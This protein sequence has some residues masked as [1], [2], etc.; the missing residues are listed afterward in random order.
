VNLTEGDGGFVVLPPS[1]HEFRFSTANVAGDVNGDSLDDF[2]I[3]IK[4]SESDEPEYM[5]VVFGKTDTTSILLADVANGLGGFAIEI[6]QELSFPNPVKVG[7]LNGDGLADIAVN[8][9]LDECYVVFGKSSTAAVNPLDLAAGNGGFAIRS[10][11]P[12]SPGVHITGA[13]D[14]NGDGKADLLVTETWSPQPN[15]IDATA[16]VVFGKSDTNAVDLVTVAA[17]LGGFRIRDNHTPGATHSAVGVGD[18]NGDGFDDVMV[19]TGIIGIPWAIVFGKASTTPVEI[20]PQWIGKHGF[21]VHQ[22]GIGVAYSAS[23]GDINGDGLSD[24]IIGFPPGFN[25]N[26]PA[27]G[28]TYVVFG[29]VP[30]PPDAD[31]DL[32]PDDVET[33][34]GDFIDA[35]DTGSNPHNFDTD[36]DGYFDGLE[37]SLDT[38]PNDPNDFPTGLGLAASDLLALVLGAAAIR[39]VAVQ[40]RC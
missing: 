12:H 34:T 14:V 17:G 4:D 38:D 33:M 39:R 24:P 6:S 36:G 40:G 35:S 20:A 30:P 3:A 16:Y 19:A 2:V 32:L 25:G 22:N 13:A 28:H 21:H 8:G 15:V 1:G 23:A 18:M 9:Q 5:Y 37:V 7:D 29:F 11:A 26:R 27:A 31:A 10:S